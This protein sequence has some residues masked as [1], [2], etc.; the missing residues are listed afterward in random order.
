M[1]AAMQQMGQQNQQL[2]MM[3]K[4]RQ[5]IEQVKQAHE[6]KGQSL[7]L[8]LKSMTKTHGQ[9]LAKIRWK[10]MPLW[11]FCYTIWTPTA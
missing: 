4:Q 5:D 1:Q 8:T 3:I 10:L 2:Q 11:N 6:D 9:L 7:M